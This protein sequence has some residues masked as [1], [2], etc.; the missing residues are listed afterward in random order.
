MG[1]LLL[2]APAVSDYFYQSDLTVLMS[3]PGV[4]S[5]N[6]DGKMSDN[7]RQRYWGSGGAMI[8]VGV[9]GAVFGKNRE[10]C[11]SAAREDRDS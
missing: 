6:L 3:R 7:A 4:Q 5:V 10:G 11:S 8:L 9:A 2:L 1:S